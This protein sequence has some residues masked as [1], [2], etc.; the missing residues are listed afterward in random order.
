MSKQKSRYWAFV[1]YPESAPS[2]WKELLQQT[3]LQYAISP[4]HDKDKDPTENDKKHHWHVIAVWS[5]P[6]T[7]A[8]VKRIT[9]SVKS[10]IPIALNAIKGYYRYLTHKDN[11][12][13]H[14][15]NESEIST[16]NGFN[17]SNYEEL[18]K[19]E[20]L[21]IK[22]QVIELIRNQE[23]N[24]YSDLIDI[25]MDSDMQVELDIATNHTIFFNSYLKSRRYK[26]RCS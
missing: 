11:P 26:E 12:E 1:V 16:L 13:K 22:K 17:I 9:D 21:T 5:G 6:T 8:A 19:Q 2:N 4:L 14:Q 24:E 20:V 25:L 15:Y 23:L 3:G 18:T 7:L 10:P